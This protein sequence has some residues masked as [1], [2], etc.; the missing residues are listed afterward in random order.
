MTHN[1]A[2][3]RAIILINHI[4]ESGA[5]EVRPDKCKL[6]VL[7]MIEKHKAP[8]LV[9]EEYKEIPLYLQEMKKLVAYGTA[10][11]LRSWLS[12]LEKI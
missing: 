10:E 5:T 1:L 4:K 8:K 6:L 11:A 3:N 12:T 2:A 9:K 7:Q